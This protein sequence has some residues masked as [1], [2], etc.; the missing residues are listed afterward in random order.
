MQASM[1]ENENLNIK[2][3]TVSVSLVDTGGWVGRKVVGR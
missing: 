2:A 1:G 3:S